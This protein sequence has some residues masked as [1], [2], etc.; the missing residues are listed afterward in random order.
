M[1]RAGV[2]RKRAEGRPGGGSRRCGGRR[3]ALSSP[4]S[5]LGWRRGRFSEQGARADHRG[6]RSPL[7]KA[8]YVASGVL[9]RVGVK[10]ARRA[11]E[12]RPPIV[13]RAVPPLVIAGLVILIAWR[14][15]SRRIRRCSRFSA[16]PT[17]S[18]CCPGTSVVSRC[19][20]PCCCSCLPTRFL[21]ANELP[22][23]AV[24]DPGLQGLPEHGH[25]GRDGDLRDDGGRAQHRRRLR[26][27]AR[28][29]LRRVLRARGIRGGMVRLAPLPEFGVDFDF[30][31]VAESACRRRR[32]AHL[33]LARPPDRCGARRVGG[34]IIG[35][36]TLRLRGDYLAIVTLGFG[37][38]MRSGGPKRRQGR[39]GL[40]PHQRPAR[41]QPDRPGRLRQLALRHAD[42]RHCLR[43]F[44]VDVREVRELR[45]P[46]TTGRRSRCC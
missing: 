39:A 13:Q 35:L 43:D 22:D 9:M 4:R 24:R 19:R 21:W 31:S 20:R 23:V 8:V 25:D 27:A 44:I 34:V 10:D 18:I 36:P 28:S 16:S 45:Q 38:I 6:R 29:R 17:C 46:H 7:G 41:H 30:G 2:G 32:H 26:R 14:S 37:E 3:P 33:D 42:A 15:A 5:S 12:R 1:T 11:G 40:Q